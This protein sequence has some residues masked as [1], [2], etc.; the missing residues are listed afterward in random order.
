METSE[1]EEEDTEI[2]DSPSRSVPTHLPLRVA[3]GNLRRPPAEDL[4]WNTKLD[5]V[6]Q[7]IHQALLLSGEDGCPPLLYLPGQGGG[8]LS[9]LESSL[10][11]HII[12]CFNSSTATVA[13]VSSYSPVSDASSAQ[14][15]WT[16]VELET[17][18]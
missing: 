8:V 14:G 2:D 4:D 13:S 18:H 15:D 12:S 11:P 5:M 3:N 6:Q 1:E 10:W 9:P 17:Y 7:L 16:V